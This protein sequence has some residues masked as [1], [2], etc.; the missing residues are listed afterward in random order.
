[1]V[2][3]FD[4]LN[5]EHRLGFQDI[6]SDMK[7]YYRNNKE[8]LAVIYI[9]TG[10]EE[11]RLKISPYF[12]SGEFHSVEMFK[13]QDFSGGMMVMAKLAVHL[14]NNNVT[15]EPL[16]LMALDDELFT[17]AI[18]AIKLRRNGISNSYNIKGGQS[19]I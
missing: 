14:F 3:E 6:R 15:V 19:Y 1:M 10:H 11:L 18:N 9:M 7:P 8:F 4:F 13:E 17:L 16:D 12:K 5:M 2:M